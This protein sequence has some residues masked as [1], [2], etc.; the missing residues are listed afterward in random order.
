[1]KW[2]EIITLR[3]GE[4]QGESLEKK[5]AELILSIDR[6]NRLGDIK[7]CRHAVMKNDLSIHLYWKTEKA[8][9]QGS[10]VGLCLTSALK[11]FGLVCHSVWVEE[12]VS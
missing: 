12:V 4:S 9:P 5:L 10:A 2:V 11:A 3:V 8:E 1:M 6:D 7:F